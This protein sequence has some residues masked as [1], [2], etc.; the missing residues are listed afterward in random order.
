MNV[1]FT[2]KLYPRGGSFET[3]I[4]VQ[5]LFE[6][7]VSKRHDVVFEYEKKTGKW[8]VHFKERK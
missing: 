3:T 5:M 8:T 6:L 1:K 7:D 4:P 2:R